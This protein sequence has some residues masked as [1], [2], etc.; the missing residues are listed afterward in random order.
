[1]RP[2]PPRPNAGAGRSGRSVAAAGSA[3]ASQD[4]GWGARISRRQ[5]SDRLPK[6]RQRFCTGREWD[7][8]TSPPRLLAEGVTTSSGFTHLVTQAPIERVPSEVAVVPPPRLPGGG[9]IPA[10][11]DP[12]KSP[13]LPRCLVLSS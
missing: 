3:A 9:P 5:L 12:S 7:F 6:A 10:G 1:M 4:R 13:N 11:R 8:T 2:D